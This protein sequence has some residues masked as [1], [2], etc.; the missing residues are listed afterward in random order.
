MN[1]ANDATTTTTTTTD[2]RTAPRH[3]FRDPL[4]ANSGARTS[5]AN[6]AAAPS[7]TSSP[8]SG[9]ERSAT[10]AQTQNIA[11]SE[12]FVLQSSAN[13]VYGYA[14]HA[15]AS[16]IPRPQPAGPARSRR[17]STIRPSI[18]SASKAIAAACAAGRSSHLPFHGKASSNGAYAT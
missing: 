11:T 13:S 6:F 8:R 7:P 17:P 16:V 9:A 10:S 12:S 14:A 5:G 1:G 15:Y 2:I 18:V 4:V 3:R